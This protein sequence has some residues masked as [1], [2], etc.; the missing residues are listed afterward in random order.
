MKRFVNQ[1]F[2]ERF[3][4]IQYR[5]LITSRSLLSVREIY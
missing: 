5:S 1:K 2:T 3:I 4:I